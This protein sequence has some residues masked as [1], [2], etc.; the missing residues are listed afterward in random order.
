MDRLI[1]QMNADMRVTD[2]VGRTMLADSLLVTVERLKV[3]SSLLHALGSI[4]QQAWEAQLSM[5]EERALAFA[6]SALQYGDLSVTEYDA[7]NEHIRER[8][9][10]RRALLQE[11]FGSEKS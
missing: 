6:I 2:N 3:G 5:L 7:L 10:V 9:A 8:V 11:K 1:E 4:E